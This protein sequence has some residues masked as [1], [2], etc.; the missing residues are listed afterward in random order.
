MKTNIL[1]SKFSELSN[2]VQKRLY[3]LT[4]SGGSLMKETIDFHI[5][6]DVFMIR[7]RNKILGWGG[8]R[9]Y[10]GNKLLMIYIDR[11]YRKI[12]LATEILRTAKKKRKFR[13]VTM[14]PWDGQS[15]KVI[16]RFQKRFKLG[17]IYL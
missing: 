5:E 13:H 17:T 11:E 12:G 4:L 15:T 7:H 9:D 10:V 6:M 3:N 14:C 1:Y 8:I 16:E 2:T